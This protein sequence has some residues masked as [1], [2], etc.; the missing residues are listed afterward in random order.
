MERGRAASEGASDHLVA[1]ETRNRSGGD[2]G[3]EVH[4]VVRGI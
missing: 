2:Y 3:G 1:T 4:Y